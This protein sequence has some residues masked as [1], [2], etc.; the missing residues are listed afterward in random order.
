MYIFCEKLYVDLTNYHD[1]YFSVIEIQD[2]PIDEL[3]TKA[4]RMTNNDNHL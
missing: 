1:T 4:G 3:C 2:W